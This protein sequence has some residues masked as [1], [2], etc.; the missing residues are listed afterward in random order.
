MVDRVAGG[1][2]RSPNIDVFATVVAVDGKT[3]SAENDDFCANPM[4]LVVPCKPGPGIEG[5]I[6]TGWMNIF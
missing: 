5:V 6:K 4:H 3:T 1:N 2:C